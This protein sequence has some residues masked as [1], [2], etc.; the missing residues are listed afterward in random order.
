MKL[1]IGKVDLAFIVLCVSGVC[2]VAATVYDGLV[3]EYPRASSAPLLAT[4][5]YI[6][7]IL[8]GTF[9]MTSQT[10][11]IVCYVLGFLMYVLLL[12]CIHVRY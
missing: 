8:V 9:L 12:S 11:K 7:F 5:V 1:H 3:T 6:P 4:W 10:G 2:A